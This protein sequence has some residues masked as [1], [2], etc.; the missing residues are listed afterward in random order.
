MRAMTNVEVLAP[1]TLSQSAGRP[2]DGYAPWVEVSALVAVRVDEWG[3]EDSQWLHWA[4]PVRGDVVCAGQARRFDPG[5]RAARL[6]TPAAT[7]DTD[8]TLPSDA[9]VR[10]AALSVASGFAGELHRSRELG[11]V[12]LLGE[13]KDVFRPRC[14][15]VLAPAL[16]GVGQGAPEAAARLARLAASIETIR[17]G[18]EH[19]ELHVLLARVA[20]YP[21]GEEPALAEA[22]L[23][24]SGPP[25]T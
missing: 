19:V 1:R 24:V 11:L 9:A 25:R 7:G 4:M 14:L 3:H 6:G 5:R 12:S 10:D 17:L 13:P 15:A 22:G 20:W 16:R 18:P 8:R 2:A 23:M 21:V